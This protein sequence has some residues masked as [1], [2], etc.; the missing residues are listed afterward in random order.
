MVFKKLTCKKF[1]QYNYYNFSNSRI[2]I[3]TLI[4][5]CLNI[6]K[7]VKSSFNEN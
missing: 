4:I 5:I 3:K 2:I 6:I 7:G 1:L